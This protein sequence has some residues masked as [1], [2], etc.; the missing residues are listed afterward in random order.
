MSEW[1]PVKIRKMT[2]EEKKYYK[3]HD[4]FCEADEIFDCPMPEHEQEILIT[5]EVGGKRIVEPD[6]CFNEDGY[7]L[8]SDIDWADVIA[9]MPYPKPYKEEDN[10]QTE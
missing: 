8:W 7:E 2:E 1:I 6:Q 3:D 4:L 10:E 9:W 5:R